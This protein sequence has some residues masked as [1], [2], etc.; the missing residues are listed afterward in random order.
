MAVCGYA[1]VCAELVL[2]HLCITNALAL[3]ARWKGTV[4]EWCR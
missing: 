1:C 2:V 4:W 3:C